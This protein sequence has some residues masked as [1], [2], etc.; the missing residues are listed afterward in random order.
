SWY[1]R[2]LVERVEGFCRPSDWQRAY[3]EINGFEKQLYDSR[4]IVQK[5]WLAITAEEQL[6]RFKDRETTPYKQYTI[7]EEDWR[8]RAK[9]NAY[10][11]AACDM[12]EKTSTPHAP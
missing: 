1:G 11:A 7:T 12:I 9:R 8:E 5:L 2:V 3:A 4:V 6:R 10:E